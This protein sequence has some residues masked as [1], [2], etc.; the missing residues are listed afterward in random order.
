MYK[1]AGFC[2]FRGLG[3]IRVPIWRD[4]IILR[5]F[6][7]YSLRV[8]VGMRAFCRHGGSATPRRW[9]RGGVGGGGNCMRKCVESYGIYSV[10][11]TCRLLLHVGF[12]CGPLLECVYLHRFWRVKKRATR[13]LRCYCLF[14]KGI[15]SGRS[16]PMAFTSLSTPVDCSCALCLLLFLRIKSRKAWFLRCVGW[17]S[18]SDFSTRS[19]ELRYPFFMSRVGMLL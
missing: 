15:F 3:D 17:F 1:R 10:F 7:V 4:F 6:G 18:E 5:G 16:N 8:V 13:Y 12:P 14:S 2:F 19:F 9:G 11:Y